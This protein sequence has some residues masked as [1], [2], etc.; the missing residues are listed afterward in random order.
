LQSSEIENLLGTRNDAEAVQA[1]V[2]VLLG[3]FAGF[4]R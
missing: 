2:D 4:R 1:E 3:A